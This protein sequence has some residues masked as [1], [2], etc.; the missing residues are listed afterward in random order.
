MTMVRPF[1]TRS[2]PGS[3]L[4]LA[5][6]MLLPLSLSGLS[7][8]DETSSG[9]T[10]NGISVDFA[11]RAVKQDTDKVVAGQDVEV[12]FKIADAVTGA[13]ISNASPGVWVDARQKIGVD[14]QKPG[15]VDGA[16][17]EKI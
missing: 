7:A 3:V 2:F 15:E 6:A 13:A 5:M 17:R 10:S 14:V 11:A 8:A 4:C 16:C 1:S 12:R 9:I